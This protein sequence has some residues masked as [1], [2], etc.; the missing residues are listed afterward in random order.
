MPSSPDKASWLDKREKSVLRA[1]MERDQD[2]SGDTPEHGLG[3]VL[4]IMR[5]KQ[6]WY[7]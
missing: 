5:N 1:A 3:A 4:T 7:Y 2:S 6:V